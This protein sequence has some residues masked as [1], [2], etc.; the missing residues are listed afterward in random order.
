MLIST[1]VTSAI[2]AI[3]SETIAGSIDLNNQAQTGRV[4]P[5]T[6][7][8]YTVR[9]G[10][11][12]ALLVCEYT[13]NDTAQAPTY[14]GV[15]LSFVAKSSYFGVGRLGV[16]AYL[17]VDPPDGTYPLI[18][19]GTETITGFVVSF[20]EVAGLDGVS[21][22]EAAGQSTIT[23]TV[24]TTQNNDFLAM[25][26]TDSG[27]SDDAWVHSSNFSIVFLT[28]SGLA[29]GGRIA[30]GRGALNVTIK[31][32]KGGLPPPSTLADVLV[33]LSPTP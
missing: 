2:S 20:T 17:M 10:T 11:G 29:F 28:A 32:G 5:G 25:C 9:P 23:G 16:A 24:T 22:G 14:N 26:E 12:R 3:A 21:S 33:A 13:L 4:P 31:A 27:A 30:P 1:L 6:S 8:G 15:P 18:L 7:V 19:N